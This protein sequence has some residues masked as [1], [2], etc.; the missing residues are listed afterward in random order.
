MINISNLSEPRLEEEEVWNMGQ[1]LKNGLQ[2]QKLHE[3]VLVGCIVDNLH[4][5]VTCT[6]DCIAEHEVVLNNNK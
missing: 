6:A 5:G 4:T 2:H 3:Q 1:E